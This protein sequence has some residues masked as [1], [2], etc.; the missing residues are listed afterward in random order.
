MAR[1]TARCR[2]DNAKGKN[3]ASTLASLAVVWLVFFARKA[4]WA[5]E[6]NYTRF[7]GFISTGF[8]HMIFS[9]V[10]LYYLQLI[11]R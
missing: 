5:T 4:R 9:K 3:L 7:T 10:I 8:R 11:A 1:A 6:S 2:N